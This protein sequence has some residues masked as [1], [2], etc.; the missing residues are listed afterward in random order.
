MPRFRDGLTTAQ[1]QQF[2]KLGN[3]DKRRFQT[4]WKKQKGEGRQTISP[5]SFR[6]NSS[7]FYNPSSTGGTE[8]T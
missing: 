3:K 5:A 1:K 6:T 8:G 2:D 4:A 7:G